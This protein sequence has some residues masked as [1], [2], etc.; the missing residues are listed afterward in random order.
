MLPDALSLSVCVFFASGV[1]PEEGGGQ[2]LAPGPPGRPTHTLP[3]SAMRD[4]TPMSVLGN[5][6]SILGE[7]ARSTA[8]RV[9][10]LSCITLGE[11]WHRL[12]TLY[13]LQKKGAVATVL[14][15]G[16]CSAPIGRPVPPPASAPR[17]GATPA[18]QHTNSTLRPGQ[19]STL[20]IHSIPL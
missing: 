15:Y 3:Q 12:L 4:P 18:E 6:D 9:A 1:S 17:C 13:I 8:S 16:R 7:A 5:S 11:D 14:V 2:G 19:V 20:P 10:T